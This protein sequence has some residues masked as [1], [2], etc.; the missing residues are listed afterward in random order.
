ML[1]CMLNPSKLMTLRSSFTLLIALSGT[2]NVTSRKEYLGLRQSKASKSSKLAKANYATVNNDNSGSSVLVDFAFVTASP[3]SSPTRASS[4]GTSQADTDDMIKLDSGSD[5][6]TVVIATLPIT[7]TPAAISVDEAAEY[8]WSGGLCTSNEDCYP[9]IRELVPGSGVETIGVNLCGCYANSRV[10]SFD[11]CQGE[12]PC[13][14]AGCYENPCSGRSAY[15]SESGLCM[16]RQQENTQSD[17]STLIEVIPSDVDIGVDDIDIT[18]MSVPIM[19]SWCTSD[20]DCPISF[21]CI[22]RSNGNCFF[23]PC[24]RCET[25]VE[26]AN[27]EMI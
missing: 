12:E 15:C 14:I 5:D 24:G 2:T 17:D 13:V 7:S 16:L 9:K 8:V 11:E 20:T 21:T 1:A 6:L 18:E 4:P 3:T 10:D 22:D 19:S 23:P 26:N 25:I 27:T